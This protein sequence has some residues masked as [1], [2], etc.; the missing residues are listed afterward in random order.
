[1]RLDRL[2]IA[3]VPERATL[4]GETVALGT[5]LAKPSHCDSSGAP[6]PNLGPWPV[7][8]EADDLDPARRAG[9]S[10]I[11]TGMARLVTDPAAAGRYAEAVEPWIAGELN[12]VVAIGPQFVSGIRLVGWC[13]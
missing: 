4:R 7:C 10:V 6:G 9:W 12:Q 11:V 1:M 8:C 3:I 5:S 2:P 13:T